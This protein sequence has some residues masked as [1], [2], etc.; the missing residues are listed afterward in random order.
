[1]SANLNMV[2]VAGRAGLTD[3]VYPVGSVLTLPVMAFGT[4]IPGSTTPENVWG[5]FRGYDDASTES[6]MFMFGSELP[7]TWQTVSFWVEGWN[8]TGGAGNVRWSINHVGSGDDATTVAYTSDVQFNAD[9]V[10]LASYTLDRFTVGGYERPGGVVT[11]SRVGGNG[12]DTLVGD[13]YLAALHIRR[14]S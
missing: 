3:A 6:L 4:E 10:G 5:S 8:F 1:M 2:G 9:R 7:Q 13:I 14:E 12:A 11:V